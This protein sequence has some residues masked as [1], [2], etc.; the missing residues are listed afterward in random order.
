MKGERSLDQSGAA[1]WRRLL[2]I[3]VLILTLAC[4]WIWVARQLRDVPGNFAVRGIDVSHHRGRIDW[5]RVPAETYR[6]AYIKATEG[7]DFR[8]RRFLENWRGARA[9]GIVPGAYHFFTLCRSGADQAR[10]FVRTVPNIR[11][12]LPPAVDLEFSGNCS[13]RPS[14]RAFR[15]ELASFL[16]RL[17]SHY[18]RR[19][20]LYLTRDFWKA[21]ARGLELDYPIWMSDVRGLPEYIP[22]VFWQHDVRG[23]VPG[24]PGETDLNVYR[25]SA[26]SFAMF[27]SR[28]E[29]IKVHQIASD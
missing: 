19:P 6:F 29:D 25:G 15:R 26:A 1:Y 2:R 8:D 14:R 24:V 20:V 10:N 4:A 11:E 3:G 12:S 28:E 9:V 17:E 13:A 7:G 5:Q 21:Y 27:L 23:Y 22:W 18:G 16:R